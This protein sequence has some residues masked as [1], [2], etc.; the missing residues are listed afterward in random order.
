MIDDV[1]IPTHG[2]Q[3][4]APISPDAPGVGRDGRRSRRPSV[5]WRWRR[6]FR[7]AGKPRIKKL[8]L[9]LIVI[10]LGILA[11]ISTLFGMMMAVASDIPQ[12]ENVTQYSTGHNSYLYDD[13]GRPIGIFAAPDPEVIDNW[14]QI[15]PAMINA[16]VAVEDKRFWSEPGIDIRGIA[17]ALLSDVTGGATQGASTITEQFVKNAL[18]EEGNRTVLEKLREAA[19]AFQLTHRWKPQ[20]ILL[21]YLNSTYFGNGAYGVESAA[22]VYFGKQLGYDP[23]AP[24]DGNTKACG[25]STAQVRLPSCASRLNYWQAAM[26]AG[27]VASPSAFDPVNDLPAAKARR[28]V[29]LQDMLQQHYID[30]TEYESG[31]S[32]PL[33]SSTDVEQAVEPNAAPYFTS[34][35]QPQILAAMGLGNGVPARVAE[36][37][38]YY[39]GLKIRTTLDLRMQEA[40]DQ[41]ITQELP[42]GA[43][44][45]TASLVAIDNKTGQVR[46]MV[47]GPIVNGQEDYN[48]DPFN[49]ATEAERQP[50]SAF[51]PF[52]LAVALEH[53]FGPD[54]VFLSAPLSIVVPN[55]DGKEIF[56]VINFGNEYQGDITLQEATDVSD[57]SVFERLG[58]YGL[59]PGQGTREVARMAK[60]AGITTPVSTNPA[61]ILGGLKIGVSPLDMAHAYETFA[62]GG[63]RVYDPV[64]G[65]P[66]DGPIGIESIQGA[67]VDLVDH[68]K[69][70]R[71]MPAGIAEDVHNML[72]GV[73]SSGTG[74]AA[75]IPGVDV[76]GKTGT[77]T[78][79]G[80][81]WFVGWTPQLTVAVWV[82]FPRGTVPMATLYNGA[83]VEGGT[84]PALIWHNFMVQ[85]LQILASENPHQNINTG[86][87]STETG[88]TAVGPSSAGPSSGQTPTTTTTPG[89]GATGAG[90]T[91]GGAGT[92]NGGTA[93]GA[94]G[95]TGGGT[96]ATGG[97]TGATGGGGGTTGGGGGTTGGGGGTTGG[98]G[99]AG[100]TTGGGTSGGAGIGGG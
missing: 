86:G 57:N 77:T 39:G 60:R 49:L 95:T 33:P 45:P 62:T 42:S 64:L 71:V 3:P 82:G 76:V 75:A 23:D 35:L 85:A 99:G 15:S 11:M 5:P 27:L 69:Y 88:T 4:Q 38:A 58:W 94:G 91:T 18:S 25:D 89:T 98:G 84:Y 59:G 55:S 72:E 36:Y 97:G 47:G 53:G 13:Q 66:D 90:G 9:L 83:P 10:G 17:R 50:G 24:G 20:K 70:K 31:N 6:R 65:S 56:H 43:G 44:W 21:E 19:L 37:R 34:W 87:S 46:A 28:E 100:G 80:D 52:T 29:V 40:A 54:S 63:N 8:R 67:H 7:R 78:N 93:P 73:V 96:G 51:K 16:I 68:P 12:I 32:Q 41:A 26:L 92:G 2:D 48:Q 74:T 79:Y 61:M 81:A 1:E 22:R 14:T 30:R